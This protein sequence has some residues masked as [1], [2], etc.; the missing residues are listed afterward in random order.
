MKN[1]QPLLHCGKAGAVDPGSL[2]LY[3]SRFDGSLV[4]GIFSAVFIAG[5]VTI[6]LMAEADDRL[7]QAESGRDQCLQ[8]MTAQQQIAR[9]I[10]AQ[11]HPQ[12]VLCR[13]NRWAGVRQQRKTAQARNRHAERLCNTQAYAQYCGLA[14]ARHGQCLQRSMGIYRWAQVKEQ[15]PC[16]VGNG[17]ENG[18]LGCHDMN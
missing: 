1:M 2:P 4:L 3:H 9:F 8:G 13:R 7:G 14:I 6:V 12:R 17:V 5:Q 16:M 18:G 15:M 10:S 11:P